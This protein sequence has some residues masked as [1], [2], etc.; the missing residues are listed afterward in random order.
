MV[1]QIKL[2]IFWGTRWFEA[3]TGVASHAGLLRARHAILPHECGGGLRDERVTSPKKACVGGY[4]W[5]RCVVFWDKTLN[6]HS[7]SLHPGVCM[8]TSNCERNLSKYW[9]EFCM[10]LAFPRE[11]VAI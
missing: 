9:W 8:G 3:L 4:D 6:S 11:G 7:A 1:Y 5:S 10:K 2:S